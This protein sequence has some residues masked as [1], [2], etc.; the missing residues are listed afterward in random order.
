MCVTS[1]NVDSNTVTKQMVFPLT[2][3]YFSVFD[4]MFSKLMNLNGSEVQRQNNANLPNSLNNFQP[5]VLKA[6]FIY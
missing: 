3:P 1:C 2:G 6:R 5:E 4:K